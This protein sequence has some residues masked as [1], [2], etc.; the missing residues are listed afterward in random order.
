MPLRTANALTVVGR[1]SNQ[2]LRRC[3]WRSARPAGKVP[4]K[5]TA[6]PEAAETAI[7]AGQADFLACDET[8]RL[9]R[10]WVWARVWTDLRV[11]PL[12]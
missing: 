9:R 4:A 10:V 8:K 7:S 6:K 3:V 2:R 5:N 12:N 1:I 11:I